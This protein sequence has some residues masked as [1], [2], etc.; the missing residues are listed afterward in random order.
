MAAIYS[1]G[2]A[3]SLG[4]KWAFTTRRV[5][6]SD[7]SG[8]IR[9]FAE[10][11]PGDLILAE[12][13]RIGSHSKIQL[14]TGRGSALTIGDRVVLCCGDR[15]APDQF[16]GRGVIDPDGCDMLAGGGV[17]GK[18]N[19][20]H[21]NMASP[22]QLK[23]LGLIT[24]AT[25]DVMNIATY[26]LAERRAPCDMTV[27]GVVGASM[28]AGKTTAT[29]A[30]A[31][32]LTKAGY[33]VAGVK[34][35]GTGAFG[36]YNAMLDAGLDFVADF[37]DVG[38]ASTYLQPIDNI[39]RGLGSI[40][41]TAKEAGAEIAVVELADGIYQKETAELLESS[42][43]IKELFDGVFFAS[44]DAV[45]VVGGVRHLRAIGF[46]PIGVS[47]KVSLSP[48]AVREAEAL[49]NVKVYTRDE[50]MRADTAKA[51]T[52]PLVNA[53]KATVSTAAA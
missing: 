34:A 11:V 19:V 25:G 16:E 17:I 40:L 48:L 2:G 6:R 31:H 36:D 22:T 9:N 37:V 39:E 52:T 46:E 20:A 41:A 53:Q 42:T 44:G 15:Y 14:T 12:V 35:T 28:N 24:D 13:T 29:A 32:G 23:P 5:N 45:S 30:L 38:M 27:I 26:G 3:A 33:K 51:L 43:F 47:G 4:A 21:A 7:V 50:L 8:L 1:N 49:T 10:A 18:V